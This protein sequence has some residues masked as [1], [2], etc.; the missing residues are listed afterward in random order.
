MTKTVAI[1]FD[2]NFNN[3]TPVRFSVGDTL[4]KELENDAYALSFTTHPPKVAPK[5]G[6]PEAALAA[7][8]RK[9]R[10]LAA[11][12][13]AEQAAEEAA[14][15][16]KKAAEVERLQRVVQAAAVNGVVETQEERAAAQVRAM[17]YQMPQDRD[18]AAKPVVAA[19]P[20]PAPITTKPQPAPPPISDASLDRARAEAQQAS[21]RK[22]A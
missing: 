3:A 6:T 13:A 17:T 22:R 5:E 19:D 12:S 18:E 21:K 8:Q 16:E 2:Y 20:T 10:A 9:Q 15:A 7:A 14:V 1:P 4:P 11:A